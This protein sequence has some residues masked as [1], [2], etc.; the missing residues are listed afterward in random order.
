M[1]VLIAGDFT[2][3]DVEN[4]IDRGYL[5]TFKDSMSNVDMSIINLE[6]PI[7][8]DSFTPIQKN[9]PNL[10]CG[11]NA[12]MIL[13]ELGFNMVTLANNHYLDYG[14]EGAENTIKVLNE[15]GIG[16]VG[17]GRNLAEA[18]KSFY[19]NK[20]NKILAIINC[21]ENEFSIATEIS[22]GSNPLNPITQW[23]AIREAK[24]K[25]D[26]VLVIV[27]GGH[28]LYQLPSPRMQQLYRFF[29]DNGADAVI[30]HHQHCYSGYEIYNGKPIFYGLGNF[31]FPN[32]KKLNSM[33]NEGYMVKLSFPAVDF[34]IIPY[35]T[36][37]V[38]NI[39][40]LSGDEKKAFFKNIDRIN[41]LLSDDILLKDEFN[42]MVKR[43]QK[44]F[45][46]DFLPMSLYGFPRFINRSIIKFLLPR[47]RMLKRLNH[48]QC[49][50]HRDIMIESIRNYIADL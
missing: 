28:E 48:I 40:I 37:D 4:I 50:S 5:R 25:A 26:Y 24:Q 31:Y 44:A 17:A 8:E 33:W 23:Y 12:C 9:G 11:K 6:C 18:S 35:M 41:R 36:L 14:T 19:Y 29:V 45:L 27:H 13:K 3:I 20:D 46:S 2:P 10:K 43:K 34:Q 22:V 32:Y 42:K 16:Y 49:E 1:N 21:C 38:G 39:T 7:V 47:K 15:Y 30:N